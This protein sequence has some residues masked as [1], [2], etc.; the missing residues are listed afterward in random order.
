MPHNYNINLDDYIRKWHTQR[1]IDAGAGTAT[2][3]NAMLYFFPYWCG[4]GYWWWWWHGDDCTD[5]GVGEGE[6]LDVEQ[7]S[8]TRVCS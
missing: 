3:Q 8:P 6:S 7:V 1:W 4:G 2:V 5:I